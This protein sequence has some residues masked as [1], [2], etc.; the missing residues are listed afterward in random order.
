[1]RPAKA[2]EPRQL[3]QQPCPSAVPDRLS[4]Q[5]LAYFCHQ[6]N[7]LLALSWVSSTAKTVTQAKS[8]NSGQLPQI[9]YWR[10]KCANSSDCE[11]TCYKF[12]RLHRAVYF[13]TLAQRLSVSHELSAVLLSLA[14]MRC[15]VFQ[16]GPWQQCQINGTYSRSLKLPGNVILCCVTA[17][18]ICG[19]PVCLVCVR[20]HCRGTAAHHLS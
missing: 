14:V 15:P 18:C 19:S 16:L 12:M 2:A 6:G 4:I 8:F 3:S 7:L 1:M 5:E 17:S 9:A 13:L 10:L 20:L 11:Q